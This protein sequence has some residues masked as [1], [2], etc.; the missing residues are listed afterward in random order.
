MIIY[1]TIIKFK[2]KRW[3]KSICIVLPKRFV[4][5]NNIKPNE[6]IIINIKGKAGNVLKEMYGIMKFS[7]PTEQLL[8]DARRDLESKY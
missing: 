2:T 3:G 8:K 1:D 7:K 6:E 5:E 4:K